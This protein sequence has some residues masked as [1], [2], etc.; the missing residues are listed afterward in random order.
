MNVDDRNNLY[1]KGPID[2]DDLW[3]KVKE[4]ESQRFQFRWEFGLESLPEKPGL[5]IIR[6]ARQSGKSTWLELQ[7]LDTLENFGLG[8]AFLLNGDSIYSHQEFEQKLVELE[9]SYQRDSVVRRLFIDEIT[10]IKEWER[11]IKR[12]IDAGHLRDV[13]IITTGSNAADLRRGSERLPGRKGK[14][15]RTEFVFL[16]ISYKEFCYHVGNEVGTFET[17]RLYA[18]IL[19]GGSPLAIQEICRTDRL[20]ETFVSLMTDWILGDLAASGRSRIF[21]LNLL[22]RLYQT[23][24]S[25]I[26]YTKL[27]KEA[28]L[29]N[30]TAALDYVERLTDLLCLLPMMQWDSER[31]T[32]LARKPCK[33][34]F[35]NLAMAWAFHP[36][37]PR[38]LHELRNLEGREKG[39]MYE[40]IVAQELW[41]RGQ[42]MIQKK[43]T[44]SIDSLFEV[45]L[46]YWAS[47]EHE[48]DF[49][50]PNGTMYEV[51]SGASS[52]AD[53]RWF[54]NVFPRQQ[55]HVV[56]ESHYETTQ[57][58]GVT[59]EEFLLEA[60]SD[61]HYESDRVPWK[62]G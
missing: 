57:I 45:D 3:P 58:K 8:T 14:L 7:L 50:L 9:G 6:G 47:L 27:A 60:D 28:G 23:S 38:Y 44:K 5:I 48:I 49:V 56:S 25:A 4:Y 62:T 31:K 43:A 34:P 59:V 46:K 39:A 61:L 24:P 55:L 17:D 15:L 41:R 16:P 2:R 12:L 13:L 18:Y 29:A 30:N 21:L 1:F 40:W 11:V 42:L 36:R 37:A 26:S 53:F 51:K 19:S 22:R 10:Q 54:Y 32:V 52:P 35:I 33:F 20:D